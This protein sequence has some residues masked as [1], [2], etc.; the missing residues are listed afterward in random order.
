MP[1]DDQ[2]DPKPQPRPTNGQ[3]GVTQTEGFGTTSLTRAAETASAA[4]AAQAQASVQARY[5]MALKQP[6]DWDTVR[7]RLIKECERPGFADVARY[8]KPIG[9]GVEGPSIRFAEAALRCMTNVLPE[10]SVVYDDSEKRI[11]RVG[12]T[13]L[14]ANVTYSTDVVVEKTVE[15]S[16]VKEGQVALGKRMNSQGKMT[17][18]VAATED[19]LLNKQNALISKALRT[20]G[21]RI[22][23]GD[24][25]DECMETVLSVQADRDAKD[26]NAAKKKVLD[27]FSQLNIMPADLRTYLGH[28]LAQVTPAELTQLRALFAALR[29]GETTWTEALEH[30]TGK[31][32][33]QEAGK[34]AGSQADLRDRVKAKAEA[35]SNEAKQ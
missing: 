4:I 13:D 19:D 7:I 2:V 30:K 27:G 5:V 12:V 1:N 35:S 15:R 33:A 20:N 9:K 34:A 26:P 24:I 25:L 10:V 29:D 17:Y 31:A 28:D 22:L 21:L 32:Q 11:V 8:H 14:E 23:P 18:L 3:A 16:S 6:R